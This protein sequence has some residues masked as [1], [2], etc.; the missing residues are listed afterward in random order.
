MQ[1]ILLREAS[2]KDSAYGEDY[3]GDEALDCFNRC[4]G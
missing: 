1:W 2:T 3:V 4:G